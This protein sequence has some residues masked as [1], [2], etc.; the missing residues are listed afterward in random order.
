M[1]ASSPIP[2]GL[3]QDSYFVD[4]YIETEF[5]T[6]SLHEGGGNFALNSLISWLIST[7][8]AYGW[9]KSEV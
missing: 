9:L 8:A 3:P 7:K 2:S 4:Q 1:P 5:T 6:C